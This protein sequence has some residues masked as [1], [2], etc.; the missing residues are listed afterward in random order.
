MSEKRVNTSFIIGL[1]ISAAAHIVA[2]GSLQYVRI[3]PVKTHVSL[4]ALTPKAS[5]NRLKAAEEKPKPQPLP[6]DPQKPPEPPK[7]VDR[8]IRFGIDDAKIESD[9][10][11]GFLEGDSSAG[12]QGETDQAAMALDPG[13]PGAAA[14]G[15]A[16]SPG[17]PGSAAPPPAG[18]PQTVNAPTDPSLPAPP[19]DADKPAADKP[20]EPK[21]AAPSPSRA[22]PPQASPTPGQ[23]GEKT[24]N[25]DPLAPRAGAENPK[26]GEKPD[27]TKV[28]ENP[29]PD[30]S[31]EDKPTKA[32]AK[33]GEEREGEVRENESPKMSS[34]DGKGEAEK[35]LNEV[36]AKVAEATEKPDPTQ[37]PAPP[38]P[39]PTPPA[40]PSQ[41]ASN[42]SP[43]SQP[44]PASGGQSKQTGVR[45][46][47]ES[48]AF[49]KKVIDAPMRD[50]RVQ[51]GR[52]LNIITRRADFTNT[53]LLTAPPRDTM[54]RISFQ[55]SGTVRKAEFVNGSATGNPNVD[56]PLMNAIYRWRASGKDLASLRPDET[57]SVIVRVTFK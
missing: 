4:A 19:P 22:A 32:D 47:R 38:A 44:S 13:A 27:A 57:L 8:N 31:T 11:L 25:P 36:K 5:L 45:S 37:P 46:D 10:W 7:D 49:S 50:G 12:R 15:S 55:K 26:Q 17:N 41:P 52:G 54:V 30:G 53:T 20:Q 3:E 33:N 34:E 23:T 42:P 51:A 18:R 6:D 14:P 21:E 35:E 29:K 28:V 16:G 56:D 2:I 1:A 39:E 43:A 9:T 24:D 48:E 40:P